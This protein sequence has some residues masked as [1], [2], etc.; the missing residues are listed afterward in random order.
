MSMYVFAPAGSEAFHNNLLK[1]AVEFI[2]SQQKGF[3]SSWARGKRYL[4]KEVPCSG[5]A[6]KRACV[7]KNKYV[8]H[9]FEEYGTE[10]YYIGS[11]KDCDRDYMDYEVKKIKGW[12]NGIEIE[13]M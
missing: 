8:N 5:T 12:E 11:L 9:D 10:V 1:Y 7:I 13:I 6:L 2:G 3:G 4:K